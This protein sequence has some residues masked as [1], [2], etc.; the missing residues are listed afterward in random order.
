MTSL[1]KRRKA[2][3]LISFSTRKAGV[4]ALVFEEGLKWIQIIDQIPPYDVVTK[5]NTM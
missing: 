5:R 3:A 2:L 4:A 1:W